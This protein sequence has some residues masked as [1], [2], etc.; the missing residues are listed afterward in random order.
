MR[1]VALLR[2]AQ[3]PTVVELA[4]PAPSADQ[5]VVEVHHSSLNPHDQMV[6]SG[7]AARYLQYRYPVVLGTDLVGRVVAVGQKVPDLQPGD[8][9]FGLVRELVASAG[10]FAEFVAVRR[11][12]IS[13]LP[14]SVDVRQAGAAGLAGVTALRCL[15]NL[16]LRDGDTVLVH[17]A[18]GGVG[19]ILVQLL[20]NRGAHVIATTRSRA[21]AALLTGLG[22]P[23]IEVA[24]DLDG[25]VLALSQRGLADHPV[26][27]V[28]DLAST[29]E[30]WATAPGGALA[31]VRTV[32]STRHAAPTHLE[33]VAG[34][35]V[36]ALADKQTLTRL[37]HALATGSVHI[38]LARAVSIDEA[39]DLLQTPSAGLGK[40]SVAI[41][42][43]RSS[44]DAPRPP[45]RHLARSPELGSNT[46]TT[47]TRGA[48]P[49][50][51]GIER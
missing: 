35:N 41:R 26:T 9:V 12:H 20:L 19:T 7:E 40:V 2:A 39:V 45:E 37:A 11:E 44:P 6:A 42:E 3:P 18:S 10:A 49:R 48:V 43:H 50:P 21:G 38:P 28:V 1:A 51:A 32:V 4:A 36:V 16:A 33:A 31:G 5:V 17:G 8:L 24:H 34:V 23:D 46:A 25:A 47:P 30:A 29:G 14:D 22:V 27:A 15:D 13:T